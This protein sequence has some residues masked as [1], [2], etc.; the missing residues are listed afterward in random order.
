MASVEVRT[1]QGGTVGR[2][3]ELAPE[4]FGIQP[5][6]P[7]MHQVVTAQLAAARSGT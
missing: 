3:V 6:V 2:S 7:V 5:N 4:V 1:R